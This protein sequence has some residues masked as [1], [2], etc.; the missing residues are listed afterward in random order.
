ME[1]SWDKVPCVI[2]LRCWFDVYIVNTCLQCSFAIT[3]NKGNGC[4]QLKSQAA[5][6]KGLF[7]TLETRYCFCGFREYPLLLY[8]PTQQNISIKISFTPF[9]HFYMC[10]RSN[11]VQR[12]IH[13]N[14]NSCCINVISSK[15]KCN[16]DVPPPPRSS[17]TWICGEIPADI[18]YHPS[19]HF[20]TF[21]KV[22][23][24]S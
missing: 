19:W 17:I 15:K 14:Q 4:S 10:C 9:N 21:E 23:S 1:Y 24:A 5:E 20:F 13:R 11:Y 2:N 3:T 16:V 6:K 8:I 7:H 22:S 18:F 12:C